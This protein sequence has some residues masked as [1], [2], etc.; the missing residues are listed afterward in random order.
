MVAHTRLDCAV[1][2]AGIMRHAA[3]QAIHHTSHRSAF[4]KLLVEQ[5]LMQNVLAD[6]VIESEATTASVMRLARAYDEAREDESAR[7]FQR[8]ATAVLKYWICKRA[9]NHVY[10]SLECFGGNGYVEESIMARLYREAPLSSIWEGSGNVICLDVLRAIER[11]PQ[12]LGVLFDELKLVRGADRRLDAF[13]DE[14]QKEFNDKSNLE[15][16]ARRIT[17]RLALALQGSLVVQSSP[18]P[19]ADAFCASRL[20]PSNGT[21]GT[22]PD[23][24]DFR[25]IIERAST[26]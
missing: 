9:P 22:L 3:A 19:V 17:E 18:P 25:S 23:S 11:E 2:S 5:P 13:V 4:G 8:I 21:Y 7:V 10:E 15:A 20:N 14:L 1:A 12:S 16:R 26:R 6:L 24:V